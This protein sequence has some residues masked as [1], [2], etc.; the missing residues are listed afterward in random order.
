[1][2]FLES[3]PDRFAD[4]DSRNN[5]PPGSERTY[6][7]AIAHA[8]HGRGLRE[9]IN[10]LDYLQELG[11]TAMRLTPTL[12]ND[13]KA[14]DY[15]GFGTNDMCSVDPRLGTLAEYRELSD[16]FTVDI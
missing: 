13:P 6:N 4:G 15:H 7:R 10:P 16:H 3:L 11:V 8:Y 2:C 1:M 14:T 12:A 5:Q 9:D